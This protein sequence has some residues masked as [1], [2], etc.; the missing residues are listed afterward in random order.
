MNT[1]LPPHPPHEPCSLPVPP[2]DCGA[3]RRREHLRRMLRVPIRLS[4]PHSANTVQLIDVCRAGV[5]FASSAPLELGSSV[6]LTFQLPTAPDPNTVGGEVVYC[7][8][9]PQSGL[10]KVGVR[11][12]PVPDDIVERIVDFV[13]ARHIP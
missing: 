1:V 3:E 12:R 10:H 8:Q 11:L 9:M 2:H 6:T 7:S 4:A 5:A 13:T